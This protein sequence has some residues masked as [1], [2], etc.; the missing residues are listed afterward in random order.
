M[1]KSNINLAFDDP[2]LKALYLKRQQA[3]N[4]QSKHF[5]KDRQNQTQES[6]KKMNFVVEWQLD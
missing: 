6:S 3:D 5:E 2:V 4:E 1:E